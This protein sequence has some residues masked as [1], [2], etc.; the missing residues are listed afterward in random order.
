MEEKR[1]LLQPKF[2]DLVRLIPSISLIVS[3]EKTAAGQPKRVAVARNK[4]VEEL[5]NYRK[6]SHMER[7]SLKKNGLNEATV[8][9]IFKTS[10]EPGKGRMVVVRRRMGHHG[11]VFEQSMKLDAITRI[12][13]LPFEKPLAVVEHASGSIDH[14]TEY[15]SERQPLYQ[16]LGYQTLEENEAILSKVLR[17][18][19]RMH[20]KKTSKD[21]IET[22]VVHGDLTTGNILCGKRTVRFIDVD[23]AGL[24]GRSSHPVF[25]FLL[26]LTNLDDTVEN[27]KLL[28]VAYLYAYLSKVHGDYFSGLIEKHYLKNDPNKAESMRKIELLKDTVKK[29]LSRQGF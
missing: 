24:S 26:D 21:P 9:S 12:Y 18:I 20:D 3:S 8:T 25:K 28:D 15:D 19:R 13:K 29:L 4:F 2:A 27:H 11:G 5:K 14:I 17:V 7:V 23:R 1:F 22:G 16:V 6:W 10:K